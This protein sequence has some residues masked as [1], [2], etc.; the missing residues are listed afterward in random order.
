MLLKCC[1]RGQ[2]PKLPKCF[3]VRREALGVKGVLPKCLPAPYRVC[4]GGVLPR[5]AVG[6]LD[7]WSVGQGGRHQMPA[8][9]PAC[10]PEGCCRNV[11]EEA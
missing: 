2:A 10:A 7:G 11:A 9:L 3:S 8:C 5:G 6:Q 4:P 1:Q